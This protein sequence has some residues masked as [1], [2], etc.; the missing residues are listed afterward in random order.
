MQRLLS[1]RVPTLPLSRCFSASSTAPFV[2][3]ASAVKALRVSTGAPILECSKAL[4]ASRGDPAAALDWLRQRGLSSA[5]AKSGRSAAQGLVGCAL[6]PDARRGVVLELNCETD[7]AARGELFVGAAGGVTAAAL[8][9]A[10]LPS[11][12]DAAA[13]TEWASRT[14][15]GAAVG[16]ASPSS[17]LADGVLALAARVRENVV[18]RR[19]G[20]LDAARGLVAGYT[21]SPVAPGSGLGGVGVLVALSP[22]DPSVTLSPATPGYTELAALARRVAMHVAAARPAYT[23]IATVPAEAAER[24]RAVHAAAM[25]NKG[26]PPKTPALLAKVVEG[27]MRKFYS[28]TVLQEQQFVLSEDSVT[29]R[30][31]VDA[32]AAAAGAPPVDVV[33]FVRFSVGEAS[34]EAA[35]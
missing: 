15:L 32:G 27:K 35:A 7:F 31:L 34:G 22:R 26:G 8:A 12:G 1:L 9:G 14:P 2:V 23:S 33:G 5:L 16:D 20:G 10:P 6:T 13:L 24:E 29:V 18:L 17:S 11:P 25:D 19:V 30:K 3:P 28:E 4:A 21:H